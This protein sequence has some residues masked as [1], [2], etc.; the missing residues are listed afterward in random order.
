MPV[1]IPAITPN[2]INRGI[3]WRALLVL[4]GLSKLREGLIERHYVYLVGEEC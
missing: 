4:C 2:P 1:F 3:N